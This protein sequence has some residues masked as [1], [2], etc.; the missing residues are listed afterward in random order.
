MLESKDATK[1]ANLVYWYGLDEMPLDGGGLR[2][3]AWHAAL[4]AIGFDTTVHSLRSVGSGVQN[5]G[6]IRSIK[7]KLIP[8][9]I[10]ERLR[11]TPAADLHVITV[12]SVF[13]SAVRKIPNES[14]IFDWMDVWSVNARTVGNASYLSTPGGLLQSRLW[15]Q[16]ER[17]LVHKPYANTFAGYGDK[18]T[19]ITNGAKGRWIPTPIS[20][21]GRQPRRMEN[22]G[23]TRVGF[24]GN[25]AYPPNALSLRSFFAKYEHQIRSTGMEFLVAG[26]GS[27]VVREWQVPATVL[28]PVESLADFYGQI[29]AAVVPVDHGGGIKAKAVEAMAYGVPLFGTPH[30]AAG[31][32]PEWRKYISPLED[33]FSS[34]RTY[35]TVPSRTKFDHQFSQESFTESVRELLRNRGL[36][37]Q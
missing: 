5:M 13:L 22:A 28:G 3:L 7:K 32:S 21:A 20:A 27:E 36:V 17:S 16:K 2:A 9:P 29:D 15:A 34:P 10:S 14:L 31:F 12:P 35:P 37:D 1:K 26:F 4:S 18:T 24:I 11:Q 30:V 19:L 8:M 33:L 25:F 6:P 23:R